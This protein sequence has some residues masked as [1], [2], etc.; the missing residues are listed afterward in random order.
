MHNDLIV[1]YSKAQQSDIARSASRNARR[2]RL[3]GGLLPGA[4]R[5]TPQPA[6]AGGML[7]VWRHG[8]P[9]RGS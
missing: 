7:H 5:S 1:H 3:L 2:R 8:S 4:P 9:A 6:P